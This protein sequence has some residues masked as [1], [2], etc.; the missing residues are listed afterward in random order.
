MVHCTPSFVFIQVCVEH[1][2]LFIHPLFVAEDTLCIQ[3]NFTTLQDELPD[4]DAATDMM[5]NVLS[6]VNVT[7]I[8]SCNGSYRQKSKLLKILILNGQFACQELFKAINTSL[9]REDLTE[10]MKSHSEG[11]S[12]R[13][14]K[15]ILI[16]NFNLNIFN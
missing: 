3:H 6:E 7:D 12:R 8:K 15:M 2:Y 10:K 5:E 4:A 1:K 9:E 13:G 11:I 14:N 16:Y